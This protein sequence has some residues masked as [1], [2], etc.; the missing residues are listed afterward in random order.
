MLMNTNDY[1]ENMLAD[2]SRST[3]K[4]RSTLYYHSKAQSAVGHRWNPQTKGLN[5]IGWTR[6]LRQKRKRG[7]GRE[8]WGWGNEGKRKKWKKKG[9]QWMGKREWVEAGI[10]IWA[11]L[12]KGKCRINYRFTNHASLWPTQV[13]ECILGCCGVPYFSQRFFS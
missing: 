7:R 9:S 12:K 2:V 1:R 10:F 13:W 11:S 3:L 6:I 5:N 8:R 4:Y